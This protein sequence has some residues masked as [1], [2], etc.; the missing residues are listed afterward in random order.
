MDP[1][2]IAISQLCKSKRLERML[3]KGENSFKKIDNKYQKDEINKDKK[4]HC[5]SIPN[6]SVQYTYQYCKFECCKEAIRWA[7]KHIQTHTKR[8][9]KIIENPIR[10][11]T[12]VMRSIQT[13]DTHLNQGTISQHPLCQSQRCAIV[14]ENISNA[15]T[16]AIHGVLCLRSVQTT[17]AQLSKRILSVV[18]SYTH[19]NDSCSLAYIWIS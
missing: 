9:L 16:T 6:L 13:R 12:T 19:Q 18:R 1:Y 3:S 15:T 11:Y 5:M 2:G 17:H 14:F 7:R 8:T 10:M 4:Q